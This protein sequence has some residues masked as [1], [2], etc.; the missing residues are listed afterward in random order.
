MPDV[1]RKIVLLDL[2]GTLTKSD[3]GILASVRYA[4]KAL[5]FPIPSEKELLRF[6]GPPIVES[7]QRNGMKKE[8]LPKAVEAY[9]KAYS[10]PTFPDPQN[11]GELAPGMYLNSVYNGIPEALATMRKSGYVL[12]IATAKPEPQAI[13]V[14]KHLGLTSQVDHIFGAS[15]DWSRLH[16]ADV[17]RYA[18]EN[19][20]YDPKHGDRAVMVGDRW[21]DIDGAREAGLE[22]IGVRWG[23]SEPGELEK[24]GAVAYA[25]KPVDLPKVVDDYFARH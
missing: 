19:L 8:Q 24:H 21:T 16:K 12:A 6:V 18:F 20:K 4:C 13:P 15:I 23:Y 17:I 22:T 9:R 3:P 25:E 1:E 2:D 5:N 7:M 10:T 14:C 11:P